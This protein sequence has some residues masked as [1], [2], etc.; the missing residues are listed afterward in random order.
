MALQN[1]VLRIDNPE[2]NE[3]ILL[4]KSKLGTEYLKLVKEYISNLDINA[5]QKREITELIFKSIKSTYSKL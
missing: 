2:T 1:Y 3:E 5:S 4:L